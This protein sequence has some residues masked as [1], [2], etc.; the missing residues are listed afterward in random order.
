MRAGILAKVGMRRMAQA[1][2]AAARRHAFQSGHE[3]RGDQRMHEEVFRLLTSVIV[4][5]RRFT[6]PVSSDRMLNDPAYARTIFDKIEQEG[7]EELVLLSLR[8]RDHLGL[9]GTTAAGAVEPAKDTAGKDS[10]K[11]KFG[12]RS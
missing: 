11:Y 3:H 10:G 5:G 7:D 8:L 9:L 12:A 2:M 4:K 1:A 6:G